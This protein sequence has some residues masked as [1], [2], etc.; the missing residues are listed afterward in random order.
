MAIEG[1]EVLGKF[2]GF[3][4]LAACLERDIDPQGAESFDEMADVHQV[5]T[6]ELGFEEKNSHS[7]RT[8]NVVQNQLGVGD[9]RGLRCL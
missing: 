3:G 4:R 5:M 2:L 6:G 9:R 7:E 1:S 8:G